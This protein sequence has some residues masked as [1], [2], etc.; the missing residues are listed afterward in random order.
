MLHKRETRYVRRLQGPKATRPEWIACGRKR[1]D[2]SIAVT[3][4]LCRPGFNFRF[5]INRA[6]K[7]NLPAAGR[8]EALF[9]LII[10]Q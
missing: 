7:L 8:Q 2:L 3:E 10:G 9:P 1:V 4:D 5:A 6:D